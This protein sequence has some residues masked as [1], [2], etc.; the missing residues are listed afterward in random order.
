VMNCEKTEGVFDYQ[1]PSIEDGLD[2][3]VSHYTIKF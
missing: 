3:V 1:I 2:E